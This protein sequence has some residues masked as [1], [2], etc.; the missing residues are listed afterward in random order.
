MPCPEGVAQLYF[1]PK[2]RDRRR[3]PALRTD[4]LCVYLSF[5]PSIS[6]PEEERR[7][8]EREGE[9]EGKGAVWGN[10]QKLQE[11]QDR[12]REGGD[13]IECNRSRH[14]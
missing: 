12:A 8:K 5:S 9:G 2:E 10:F 6:P 4:R 11:M 3:C 7:M 13:A 1:L 14:G